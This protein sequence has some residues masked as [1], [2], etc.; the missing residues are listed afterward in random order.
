ME[1]G[2]ASGGMSPFRMITKSGVIVCL[3][4]VCVTSLVIGYVDSTM[5]IDMLKLDVS[6]EFSPARVLFL[7]PCPSQ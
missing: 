3:A 2:E 5:T 1:T 4:T 7:I 6:R